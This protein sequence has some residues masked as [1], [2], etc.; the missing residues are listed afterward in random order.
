VSELLRKEI[1][2]TSF[3]VVESTEGIATTD[4]PSMTAARGE[5]KF[6]D[7]ISSCYRANVVE[8]LRR[9]ERIVDRA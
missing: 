5:L 7:R 3:R 2:G 4:K 6:E 8:Y 1:T 9:K